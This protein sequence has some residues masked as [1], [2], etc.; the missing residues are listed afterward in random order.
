M[1]LEAWKKPC[2][3]LS[4]S[5]MLDLL[6]QVVKGGIERPG[7]VG[8]LELT[9]H[10]HIGEDPSDSPREVSEDQPFTANIIHALLRGH[11]QH[12]KCWIA[13]TSQGWCRRGYKGLGLQITIGMIGC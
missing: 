4:R 13:S 9:C 10:S 1:I 3:K 7:E 8:M 2:L 6:W 5:E 11:Q 12:K